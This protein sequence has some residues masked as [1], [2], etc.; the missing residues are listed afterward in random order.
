[1]IVMFMLMMNKDPE[2]SKQGQQGQQ[3]QTPQKIKYKK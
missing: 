3:Q 2:E 1:M